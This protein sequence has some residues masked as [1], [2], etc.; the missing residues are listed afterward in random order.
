MTRLTA[1]M[2]WDVRL[3]WRNGFYYAILV[4]LLF[5]ALLISQIPDEAFEFIGGKGLAWMLPAAVLSNLLIG[6]FYFMGGLLLLEKGE[7]TLTAQIVTPLRTNEYL[8]SKLGT[9]TFLSV[10]ENS[11]LVGIIYLFRS[12]IW[13]HWGS[14]EMVMRPELVAS[15]FFYLLGLILGAVML[16]LA[17]FLVV[18][19]YDSI[20]EYLLPSILITSLLMLPLLSYLGGWQSWLIYLH[21]LQAPL[22]LLRAAW[23]PAVAWQLAYAL[24]YSLLWIGLLFQA[25]RRAFYHFV[26]IK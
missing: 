6:T 20:N 21:P 15:L 7:G 4:V 25:A 14:I 8:I 2:Q 11:L 19:R 24:F 3:Q 22:I 23:Q 13:N 16:C 1:T 10:I 9:L 17:G 5:S 12:R 26:I 18:I